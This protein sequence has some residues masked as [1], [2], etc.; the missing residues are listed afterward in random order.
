[1]IALTINASNLLKGELTITKRSYSMETR[2][3]LV[4]FTACYEKD[5][6]TM[7]VETDAKANVTTF[8]DEVDRNGDYY[9]LEIL[10]W[11]LV[12]E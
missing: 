1:M 9:A 8:L 7:Y 11:S 3:F 5:I 2:T 10:G 4:M 12:E 6:K